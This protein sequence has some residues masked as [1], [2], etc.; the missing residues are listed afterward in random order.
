MPALTPPH[1]SP[2]AAPSPPRGQGLD[3]MKF[4][5]AAAVVWIHTAAEGWWS[6]SVALSRFAV[7]FFAL[8]SAYALV[9]G[10]RS[11]PEE[12]LASIARKRVLRLY[13]PFLV[14]GAVYLALRFIKLNLLHESGPLASA[15]PGA[16]AAAA[17]LWDPVTFFFI[18]HAQQLWFLP[19]ICLASIALAAL[20]HPVIG[21]PALER[22][23]GWALIV[24]GVVVALVMPP[25]GPS[26]DRP[27]LE[28]LALLGLACTPALLWGAAAP[29]LLRV[30]L[31]SLRV[32]IWIGALCTVALGITMWGVWSGGWGLGFTGGLG[33]W[34]RTDHPA[35]FRMLALENV[36]GVLAAVVAISLPSSK[37]LLAWLA[38]L[39]TLAF[40]MYLSH[41]LFLQAARL[42][43][44]K[45]HLADSLPV[46]LALW[47][48]AVIGAVL[49]SML[50]RRIPATRWLI[51]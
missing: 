13:V 7:P 19:Y 25:S 32:P 50:L 30:G 40:G 16:P 35:P 31:G 23:M 29:L 6:A 41:I 48:A 26:I 42:V 5:A 10:M 51:P 18:G 36:A 28:N 12:S 11:R 14:W 9:A 17:S 33:G 3:A 43:Q 2:V 8:V 22:A 21:K 45:A 46:D 49:L 24:A 37:G 1:A 20:I 38:T 39:G 15:A 44:R 47:T 27:P 34:G 4:V